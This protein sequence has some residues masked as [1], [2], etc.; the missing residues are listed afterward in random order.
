MSIR[1]P[2]RQKSREVVSFM[3][4]RIIP[5]AK[6]GDA[7]VFRM[8]YVFRGVTGT[9]LTLLGTPVLIL[10]LLVFIGGEGSP[11]V[12]FLVTGF[13]LF[14]LSA[15]I[16]VFTQVWYPDMFTFDNER[17]SL[18][19]REKG[20]RGREYRLPYGEIAGFRVRL[21]R[22]DNSSWFAL[23]MEK[24]DGASWVLAEYSDRKK[25][26]D[27]LDLVNGSLDLAAPGAFREDVAEMP[28]YIGVTE[29]GGATVISWKKRQSLLAEAAGY[30]CIGGF[31]MA[32]YGMAPYADNRAA[33]FAALVF[34]SLVSALAVFYLFYNINRRYF[35]EVSSHSLKY[36]TRG[37]LFHGL[38]FEKPMS[39]IDAVLFHFS[40]RKG[41]TVIH[42]LSA[43]ERERLSSITRGEI[44]AGDIIDAVTF[45]AKV[46][47]IDAGGLD[48]T[49]KMHLEEIGRAHV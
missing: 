33:Y 49:G 3:K 10:G 32:I 6:P 42:V 28:P 40:L 46:T 11:H 37:L 12:P 35:V 13:G 1:A 20:K 44:S 4:Y 22:Y 45:M 14:L 25:A 2:D 39:S 16:L 31:S 19:V 24:R 43:E 8:S 17:A 29:K 34:V 15:G 9:L 36:Y 5:P 7:L 27:A 38:R 48:I 18:I 26:D 21:H 23:E 30:L 47:R 41:D